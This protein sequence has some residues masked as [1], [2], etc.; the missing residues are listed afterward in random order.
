MTVYVSS[1]FVMYPR[2]PQDIAVGTFSSHWAAVAA[3]VRLT[4]PEFKSL[5]GDKQED[6][7][8]EESMR[9]AIA[10]KDQP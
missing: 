5:G 1:Q 3:M 10:V 9:H 6:L 8:E 4:H 2:W 7:Q